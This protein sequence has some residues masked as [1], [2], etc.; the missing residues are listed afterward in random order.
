M[1]QNIWIILNTSRE[2]AADACGLP[3][4]DWTLYILYPRGSFTLRNVLPWLSSLVLP[5]EFEIALHEMLGICINCVTE[6]CVYLLEVQEA[7][8]IRIEWYK[9]VLIQWKTTKLHE[10]RHFCLLC[11][12][13]LFKLVYIRSIPNNWRMLL[14]WKLIKIRFWKRKK[15]LLSVICFLHTPTRL[16]LILFFVK[17]KRYSE[18]THK[19]W[20]L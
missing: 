7:F 1:K 18:K 2:A 12:F 5:P 3:L 16:L 20:L 10:A 11:R 9:D 15:E 6:S 14:Q 8:S 19:T 17:F 4:L 13:N